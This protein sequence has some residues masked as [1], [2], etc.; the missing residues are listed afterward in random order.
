MNRMEG[1]GR[2]R[3]RLLCRC[4]SMLLLCVAV[5][6]GITVSNLDYLDELSFLRVE[7]LELSYGCFKQNVHLLQKLVQVCVG[8][9]L[10]RFDHF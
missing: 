8:V 6:D 10:L 4:R 9:V 3:I 2:R 5:R 7:K 1:S